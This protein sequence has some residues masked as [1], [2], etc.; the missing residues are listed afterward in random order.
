LHYDGRKMT[1]VEIK[2]DLGSWNDMWCNFLDYL[3]SQYTPIDPGIIKVTLLSE[4]GAVLHRNPV[5]LTFSSDTDATL[6]LL[7]FS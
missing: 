7:R 5:Y 2:E 3:R 4:W 6:F 1:R